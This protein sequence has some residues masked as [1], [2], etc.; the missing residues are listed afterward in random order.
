MFL[1]IITRCYKRPRMLEKNMLS[2]RMQTNQDFEQLFLKDE[3]G[4][5]IGWANKQFYRH[6]NE[7]KGDYIYMLDDDDMLTDPEAIETMYSISIDDP[8]L[9]MFKFDCGPWG[10]LPTD[11]MWAA[12]WPKVTHVGTPC[13]VTRRDIWHQYIREFGAP[14]AGDYHFLRAMW[15]DLSDV[16]WADRVIGRIQKGSRGAPERA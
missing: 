14:T 3:A 15:P 12:Q 7:P 6:R 10:I 2:L 1:S 4:Y 9:I 8:E 13:F 5:G 11:E 16:V